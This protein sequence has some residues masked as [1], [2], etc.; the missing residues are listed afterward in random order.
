[1]QTD[2]VCTGTQT[3]AKVDRVI[4]ISA[5]S[6]HETAWSLCKG[7]RG[8]LASFSILNTFVQASE[9]LKTVDVCSE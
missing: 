8:D 5:G 6:P 4:D 2:H 7:I 9:R 3:N 1:M